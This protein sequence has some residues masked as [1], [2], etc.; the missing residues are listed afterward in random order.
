MPRFYE[1]TTAQTTWEFKPR[2]L[3]LTVNPTTGAAPLDITIEAIL[4]NEGNISGEYTATLYI[5][6]NPVATQKIIINPQQTEKITFNYTLNGTGTYNVTIDDLMPITVTVSK[7]ADIKFTVTPTS[8]LPPLTITITATLTNT[9]D[10]P[11][12]YTIEVKINGVTVQTKT[13]SLGAG[14]TT[15]LTFKHTLYE[16]GTYNISINELK[17]ITVTVLRPAQIILEE[18]DIRWVVKEAPVPV[19]ISCKLT[20]MGDIDGNY[21]LTV[22]VNGKPVVVKTVTVN[23]HET[24]T[25]TFNYTLNEPGTYNITVNEMEGTTIT[26]YRPANITLSNLTIT[27]RA[28]TA[29]LTI[30]ISCTLTNNGDVPGDYTAELKVNGVTVQTQTVII[31]A[32]QTINVEFNWTLQAGT[33]NVTIGNLK[34]VTVTVASA[35]KLSDLVAA[36]KSVK[37]YYERYGKLPTSITIVGQKYTMAQLLYLLAKATVN[38]N[39]G[40]LNPIMPKIVAAPTSSSGSYRRGRLYKTEYLKVANNILNYMNSYGRAPNYATTSLGRIPF[41]RLVYIYTKIIT[42]YGTYKRLPSYVTT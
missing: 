2:I 12:D 28:G 33:Y 30:K 1:N 22:Y 3:N 5:N 14:A 10:V 37:S 7:P 24:K 38:I 36:S 8:G 15:N 9:G 40:N 23:A 27:P 18:L 39:A 11:R 29:P 35:I 25:I 16:P 20:N 32:G 42:Y 34:P 41:T 17:P 6:N 21:T 26:V 13:I 4:T 19:E 31:P